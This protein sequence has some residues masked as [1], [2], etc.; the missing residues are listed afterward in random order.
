LH[1][2]YFQWLSSASWPPSILKHSSVTVLLSSVLTYKASQQRPQKILWWILSH[3]SSGPETDLQ[4][5]PKL[6]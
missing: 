4:R 5:Y 1:P 2:S 6:R 3:C